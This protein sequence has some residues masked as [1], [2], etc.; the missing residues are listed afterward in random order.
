[1][2]IYEHYKTT[3]RKVC[4]WTYTDN[5]IL[6]KNTTHVEFIQRSSPPLTI[7]KVKLKVGKLVSRKSKNR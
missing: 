3:N 1:M 2:F 7:N 4:Q 6:F 5:I